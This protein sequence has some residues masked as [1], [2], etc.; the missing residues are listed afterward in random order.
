V[1]G[2]TGQIGSELVPALQKRYGA[3]NVVA[4]GHSRKPTGGPELSLQLDVCDASAIGGAVQKYE[5]DTIFHLAALL[6]VVAE[7]NPQ[8]A[9]RVNM[10]GLF[11]V[12]E[13]CREQGCALFFPSSIGAFGAS[14]PPENTPQETIQRPETIYGICKVSGELLCDYYHTRYGVDARGVRFPGLI[15][16]LT[17]PGGGTTDYAVE[18][19]SAALRENTYVCFL[20][21]G[22]RLDMMYM[23][24]AVRAAIELMEAPAESLQHRNAYNLSAF[25][26]APEDFAAAIQEELPGFLIGYRDDPLRQKIADSWPRHIDDSAARRDWGWRE[27]YDLSA[28]VKAM[29][30]GL[31]EKLKLDL[32]SHR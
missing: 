30:A 8:L 25:C 23:D 7:E 17:V 22:T 4:A 6:S 26:A 1:T 5:I 29:L 11:N 20:K 18:I 2:A 3:E 13:V 19:F 9:W 21:E 14:T 27:R 15:S 24:D 32:K 12:L 16:Y 28:T 31:S 10:D